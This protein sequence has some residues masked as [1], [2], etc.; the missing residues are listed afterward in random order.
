MNSIILIIIGVLY[1][2]CFAPYYYLGFAVLSF[3]GFLLVLDKAKSGKKAFYYGW[4]FAF[5]HH[6][7]G[8]Y[9]VSYSMLVEP[10]KFAWMIPFSATALPAYLSLY[11]GL[12]AYLI[13]KFKFKRID[14]IIF[15]AAIWVC[16]EIARGYVF[17][18]F[19]WN[20]TGYA[21]LSQL[22]LAQGASY[23]GVYGLSFAAILVFASPYMMLDYYKKSQLP[24]FYKACISL[25]YIFPAIIFFTF[26][27]NFG[28]KTLEESPTSYEKTKIRIVQPN[29]PQKEK[30]DNLRLGDQIFK[31][32]RLTLQEPKSPDFVPDLIVWPEA[33]TPL[34]L[35]VEKE[36]LNDVAEVIPYSAF[37]I[38]GSLR[39][40][41][42]IVNQKF[43][44]S[45]EFIDSEGNLQRQAYD[46]FHLV[47]FGEY[48]PYRRFLPGVERIAKG[49]GDFD[50][51]AGPKTMKLENSPP[52]S[53]LICYEILFS[54]NVVEKNSAQKPQW[55]L[56]LTNDA[57]F[58]TTSGP[59]Q[60]LD[61]SR[62]RAIEQGLPVIRSANTGIS[63][64]IDSSGRI[65]QHIKL[66]EEGIIDSGLPMPSTKETYFSKNGNKTIYKIIIFSII[67]SL[68]LKYI[69]IVLLKG[70]HQTQ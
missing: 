36:F 68:F 59:Y 18:G 4:L 20:L 12:A 48:V 32:Y 27:N 38:L 34:N 54:G 5:A 55:I 24:K 10:E 3:T 7:T 56:N 13:Y 49:I 22:S 35:A 44:N 61:V 53:P 39:Q 8:I 19:P 25:I 57:W 15:F 11:V 47:P 46:K 42:W 14:K 69:S 33:A 50:R 30:F 23:I 62:M 70:Q 60:H 43:F 67:L 45:I 37:L 31:Y 29:I 9:W 58:G 21:L 1:T 16:A 6:V 17:T 26:A 66:N 64:V 51:G 41:G 40:E 52:F 63:A 65:L 2:L 28:A